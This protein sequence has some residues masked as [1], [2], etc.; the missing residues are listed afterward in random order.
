MKILSLLPFSYPWIVRHHIEDEKKIL[1][2][3]CGDGAFMAI[4]NRD[5]KYKVTGVD[6]FG[7]YLKKA[8]SLGVYQKVIK[9]DIRKIN[10]K[11]NSFDVVICSQVIEHLNKKDGLVL[12]SKIKQIAPKVIIGTPNG[13]FS[14]EEYDENRLQ[15]HRSAWNSQDFEKLGFKVYGQGLKLIYGEDGLMSKFGSN[16]LINFL[17]SITSY[18]LSPIV[19]FIPDLGAHIIAVK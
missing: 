4:L 6:L 17:L 9:K 2:V 12:I 10:F 15:Q 1:D 11:K 19:Y 14:Q 5:K 16:T 18:C 8:K 13:R 3:G 7:P